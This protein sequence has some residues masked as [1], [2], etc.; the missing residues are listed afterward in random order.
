MEKI[1]KYPLFVSLVLTGILFSLLG[2]LGAG[3]IYKE[4]SGKWPKDPAVA[5]V[6]QGLSDGRY[7]GARGAKTPAETETPVETETPAETEA[8]VETDTETEV[9][10][11]NNV[12]QTYEFT[13]VE[14][15]YFDDAVFIGDSRTVG[16]KDYSGWDQPTYYCSIGLNIYKM[17][18]AEVVE[19]D[20]QKISIE[21]AL[22]KHQFKKVYLMIGINE[23]G[24]GT[25]DKFIEAYEKAVL[26]I[27]EL[28]PEAIIFIQA[29]MYVRQDKSETDPIFNNPGI[30]ERNDRIAALANNQDIFYIDVNEVVT[31]KT[32]NLNPEYTYDEIHLLGRHYTIWMEFL[33]DHGIVKE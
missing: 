8:S 1:K 33:M 6:F 2:L 27:K 14:E 5:A 28:Q 11:E 17:F 3:S 32:G 26:H 16:L 7:P 31:D 4:Y 25:V 12:P 21:K 29:I 23:M 13:R 22:K 18:D 19:E 20:D 24:D 10:E 15:S 9:S 30:K